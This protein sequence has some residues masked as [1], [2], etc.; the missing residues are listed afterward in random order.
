MAAFAPVT[1]AQ[2]AAQVKNIVAGDSSAQARAMGL[3]MPTLHKNA[4]AHLTAAVTSGATPSPLAAVA[5]DIAAAARDVGPAQISR[6]LSADKITSALTAPSGPSENYFNVLRALVAAVRTQLLKL[7]TGA[8]GNNVFATPPQ[9][10]L[11]DAFPANVVN[12]D[13]DYFWLLKHQQQEQAYKSS[14]LIKGLGKAY[15]AVGDKLVYA[16]DRKPLAKPALVSGGK[17]GAPGR[18]HHHRQP[19]GTRTAATTLHALPTSGIGDA[20][21]GSVPSGLVFPG[22]EAVRQPEFRAQSSHAIL[23]EQGRDH[24]AIVSQAAGNVAIGVAGTSGPPLA[25]DTFSDTLRWA[26]QQRVANEQRRARCEHVLDL[27]SREMHAEAE[28]Q[29]ALRG[30]AAKYAAAHARATGGDWHSYITGFEDSN[31]NDGA[32]PKKGGG[33]SASAVSELASKSGLDPKQRT[34]SLRFTAAATGGTL[35]SAVGKGSGAAKFTAADL[36]H[37]RY[38]AARERAESSDALM[39]ILEDYRLVPV[40]IAAA[41][42]G[43]TLEEV[44]VEYCACVVCVG[45]LCG[46]TP[47]CYMRYAIV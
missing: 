46:G 41:Y 47:C 28:R 44:R 23:A 45:H 34:K 25:A 6:V 13:P 26:E 17:A 33:T 31:Q 43:Q 36:A 19:H 9:A 14:D 8:G 7:Q 27:L 15:G 5:D 37:A 18:N 30:A 2:V 3:A 40:S 38:E 22:P 24:L 10:A 39:R 42:L 32:K 12:E 4:T 1:K 29:K 35:S 21:I 16:F 20:S 11:G